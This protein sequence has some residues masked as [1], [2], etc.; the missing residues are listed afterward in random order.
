MCKSKASVDDEY[1]VKQQTVNLL[2]DSIWDAV[3][4]RQED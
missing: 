2:E 3:D 1:E 4:D